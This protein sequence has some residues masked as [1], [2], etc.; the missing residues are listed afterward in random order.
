MA[1]T[2]KQGGVL[3][4]YLFFRYVRDPMQA[5][6]FEN[7]FFT[8]PATLHGFG[9]ITDLYFAIFAAFKE[10][11]TVNLAQRLFKVIYFGRN[12]KPMS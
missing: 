10:S 7:T 8:P 1:L 9:V 3:S 6:L 11:M 4:P 12:R 5:V 2:A